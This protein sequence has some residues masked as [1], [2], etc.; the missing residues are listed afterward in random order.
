[1]SEEAN[2]PLSGDADALPKT[3]ASG[4]PAGDISRAC[5]L[6]SDAGCRIRQQCGPIADQR[7]RLRLMAAFR[8]A[9][10]TPRRPG[11]MP[12][13]RITAAYEDWLAGLRGVPLFRKHIR[14]FDKLSHWRRIVEQ[15]QLL[16]AINSRHRRQQPRKSGASSSPGREPAT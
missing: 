3:D 15:R 14:R 10:V 13:A 5:R 6:A 16:A 4:K 2:K 7:A 8:S 1:M 12:S 11:R 9:L